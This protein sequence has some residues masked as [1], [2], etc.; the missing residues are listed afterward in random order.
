MRAQSRPAG[1]DSSRSSSDG[2][3]SRTCS[4]G[5]TENSSETSTPIADALRRGAPRDAVLRPRRAAA[6]SRPSA[7]GHGR[8]RGA[9]QHHAEQ[10]AG[11]TERQHLQQVDAD[12]LPAARADALQHGDAAHLLEHEDARDARHRDA[13][14]NHDDQAD[15]AQIVLGAIEVPADLVVG[16]P[17]RSGVDELVREVGA[18]RRR[19]AARCDLR[20]R[21]RASTRRSAAAEAQQTGRGQ[22]A[23]SMSTR[24]PRLK[25]PI[26]RPGSFG[27]TPRIVNVACPMTIRSPT[28][29]RRAPS[30]APDE[31]A[32]RGP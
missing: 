1:T 22:I 31:R 32:R 27:M 10:A 17:V 13:A 2:L 19:P 20:A 25:P 18:Q 28:F 7:S 14:E 24:G 16:R 11:Q 8:D 21:A 12:D 15:Q 9:R 23:E 6:S 26:R 4:S 5:T 3:T 30:A 29:R